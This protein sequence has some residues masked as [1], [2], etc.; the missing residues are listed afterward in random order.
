M[1]GSQ[2]QLDSWTRIIPQLNP[3]HP[4]L[5][6]RK[7][8]SGSFR[9]AGQIVKTAGNFWVWNPAGHIV[10]TAGNFLLWNLA[11]QI[12]KTANNFWMWNPAG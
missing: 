12:V 6:G 4:Q 3:V 1:A 7:V 5:P 10:K 8:V 11:G 2:Q 9:T